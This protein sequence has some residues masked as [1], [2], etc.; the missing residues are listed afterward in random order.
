MM[1]LLVSDLLSNDNS[2]SERTKIS[3][4]DIMEALKLCLHSTI[5]S[6]NAVLY[7]QTLGAPMESIERSTTDS[8][9]EPTRVWIRHADDIFCIIKTPVIDDFFTSYRWNFA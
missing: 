1:L 6:F 3:A 8:F 2:L 5:F 7:R 4:Q 9:Q